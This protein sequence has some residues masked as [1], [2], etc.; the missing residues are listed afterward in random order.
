[1]SAMLSTLDNPYNPFEDFD[2]WYK[3]DT[4]KGY[5]SC[6]YLS[7]IANTSEELPENLNDL[8]I[9]RAIDEICE[10]NINGLFIKVTN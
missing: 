1:M 5:N 7:R 3:Y 8:E 9:E 2:N 6:S 4:Q 10:I